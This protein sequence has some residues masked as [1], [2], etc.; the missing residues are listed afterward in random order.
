MLGQIVLCVGPVNPAINY[1]LTNCVEDC[2]I[3][4]IPVDPDTASDEPATEEKGDEGLDWVGGLRVLLTPSLRSPDSAE[5][6]DQ[7]FKDRK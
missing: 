7:I 2:I 1:Q 3:Y 4:S 5:H 6:S